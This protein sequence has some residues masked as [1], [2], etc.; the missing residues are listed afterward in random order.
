MQTF[1][2]SRKNLMQLM[3]DD[4]GIKKEDVHSH[5]WD[6]DGTLTVDVRDPF[7]WQC[8]YCDEKLPTKDAPCPVHGAPGPA[9]WCP[10]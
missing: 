9:G 10:F 6:D 2:Y 4:A 5:Y 1:S 8:D 7:P 3:L